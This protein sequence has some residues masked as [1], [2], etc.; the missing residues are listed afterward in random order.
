MNKTHSEVSLIHDG[1][2]IVVN[3]LV[4]SQLDYCNSVLYGIPT[5]QRDKL[6]CIQNMTASCDEF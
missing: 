1:L 3:A 6:Q 4:I 2:K 5:Y